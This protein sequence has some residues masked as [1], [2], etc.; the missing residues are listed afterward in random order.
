MTKDLA[1][2]AETAL[3]KPQE[4]VAP[5]PDASIYVGIAS[6]PVEKSAQDILTAPLRDDEIEIRPDD[7]MLYLPQTRYRLRLNQAF[8]VGGWALRLKPENPLV[9]GNRVFWPGMLYAGGRFLAEAMG[10]GRWIEKN[11]KST[12][13]TATESAKS[14]CLTRCCKDIGVGL[15][16]WDPVFTQ[17]WKARWAHEIRNP[18]N[19]GPPTIWAK[20]ETPVGGPTPPPPPQKDVTADRPPADAEQTGRVLSLLDAKRWAP[21]YRRNWLRK[22][23]GVEQVDELTAE[24]ATLALQ[25]LMAAK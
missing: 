21:P 1:V 8:G 15:E 4:P 10:E 16:L 25:M 19:Y 18:E 9:Q 22:H 17:K 5:E 7:G 6:R 2:V 13:G 11:A 14:D 3:V 24:K 20:R 23:F 12:Y